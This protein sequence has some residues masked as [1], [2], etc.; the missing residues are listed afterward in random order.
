MKKIE[1]LQLVEKTPLQHLETLSE[2]L[3]VN[4]YI[5]R[6][7]M[8]AW[9]MGG[10]KLRKLEY[11]MKDALDK[12][13]TRIITVGGV[14]T[15][16]GRL[17]AAVAAKYGLK[18]TI[19]A[20][21]EYPGEISANILLDRILGSDF[22]L[23]KND[24]RSENEQFE[25]T[26]EKLTKEYEARGEVVY[27]I[28]MGG[29]NDLG[30]L[31]YYD[32]ATELTE[33]AKEMKLKNPRVCVAVG[34]MGTYLGLFLGLKEQKSPLRLTGIAISPFRE[35]K[36]KRIMEYFEST[37][38]AYDINVKA[39]REDMDIQKDFTFGAYNNA[40]KEVREA[41]TL[42]A[43]K[44]AIFLDPCYTGKAFNG[45]LEMIK[46]GTIAKGEDVIFIHTGGF[47]G[48]YSRHHRTEFERE[49]IT[50][51]RVIE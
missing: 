43:R 8:T 4:L 34:S 25:S 36:E 50:G 2:E 20:V 5:K 17:T 51:I 38:K 49:L 3:G 41:I 12:G 9:G 7:D 32:C 26:I 46:N 29:S 16:H 24:G 19:I 28:P 39:T 44:E 47:P 22:I 33:Q 21:D 30:A 35:E 23:K 31:G 6:D 40:I 13:A 42:M 18:S 10:N 15:N 11:L 14:Q 27:S 45:V 1:K 48:I 37:T